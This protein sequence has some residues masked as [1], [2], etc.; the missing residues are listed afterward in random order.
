[1]SNPFSEQIDFFHWH[2]QKKALYRKSGAGKPL[3]ILHGWGSSSVVMQK[4]AHALSSLRTVWSPDLPGFGQSDE[5]PKAW[6]VDD[7]VDWTLAF[8]KECMQADKIDVLAHSYGGRMMLKWL[9]RGGAEAAMVD[10]VLITG[11]A[12]LKP[13][14]KPA[15]YLKKYTAKALKAPIQ[16]LPLNLQQPAQQKL[17]QTALWKSLGSSDYNQLSGIMRETFV[18][19]VSEFLDPLLP[20]IDHELFLLWGEDDQA[21]PMDQ[22]QRWEAGLKHASLV[23]IPKAG[24]YAFLDQA[25]QFNAI[26]KAYFGAE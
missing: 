10:K 19:S 7:Y 23:S 15:F 24:H 4:P 13:K 2:D 8:V 20:K 3:L 5:P 6:S 14:R 12:G 22:A 25:P 1:M 17:R 9:A 21:T 11:G 26:A 18:K 16:L